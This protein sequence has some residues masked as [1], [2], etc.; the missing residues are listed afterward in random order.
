ME[1][2]MRSF[3]WPL[4]MSERLSKVTLPAMDKAKQKSS[5][6][7]NRSRIEEE[8]FIF[9]CEGA[10]REAMYSSGS[11]RREQSTCVVNSYDKLSAWVR[12][13]GEARTDIAVS[14]CPTGD[15]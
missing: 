8:S 7:V 13:A 10:E 1:A 5:S 11:C 12:P 4:M 14:H 2:E 9:G 6:I 3:R 15:F